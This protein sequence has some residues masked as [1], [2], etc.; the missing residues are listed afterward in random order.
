MCEMSNLEPHREKALE[1][2]CAAD[3]VHDSGDRVKLLGLASA[4][5]ALADY[6]GH[7]HEDGTAG[8]K[9]RFVP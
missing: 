2:M 4:Y 3:E 8:P 7:Q 9:Q 6:V 5:S 1:R